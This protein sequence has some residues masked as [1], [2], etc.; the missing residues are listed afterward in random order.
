MIR[1][2]ARPL[3]STLCRPSSPT[4]LRPGLELAAVQRQDRPVAEVPVGMGEHASVAHA[5]S[6]WN[7]SPCV[8]WSTRSWPAGSPI[9][10]WLFGFLSRRPA[11]TRLDTPY[12]FVPAFPQH[13]TE[14][15]LLERALALGAQIR[16]CPKLT[17]SQ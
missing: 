11:M 10:A 8:G 6:G 13:R 14:A 2:P 16:R 7:N 1:T 17:L 15:V 5:D 3:Q 4:D 12:P 9:P